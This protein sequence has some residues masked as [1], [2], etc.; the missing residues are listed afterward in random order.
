[1]QTQTKIIANDETF[2]SLNLHG[3]SITNTSSEKLINI[4]S[5]NLHES[6]TNTSSEKLINIPSLNLYDNES[7]TNTNE[8]N[9]YLHLFF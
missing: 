3:K 8:Y 1:M 6:I 2:M 9:W 5:L 4:P 7:I